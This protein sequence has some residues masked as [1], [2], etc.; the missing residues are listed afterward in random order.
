MVYKQRRLG[1]SNLSLVKLEM[2]VSIVKVLVH[3]MI[4]WKTSRGTILRSNKHA[5]YNGNCD[6]LFLI[7]S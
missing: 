1:L 4:Q 2:P 5:K 3:G 6:L 7:S